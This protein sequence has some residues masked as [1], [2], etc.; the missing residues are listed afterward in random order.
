MA[1]RTR[2]A[3][4]EVDVQ[5]TAAGE[6]RRYR[7]TIRG[8]LQTAKAF[9]A[10]V[11][12][13]LLAGCKPDPYQ[14]HTPGRSGI[15]LGDALEQ[16]WERY[17]ANGGQART[18]RSNMAVCVEFFGKD[19]DLASIS[20]ADLD[21]FIMWMQRRDYAPSTIRSKYAVLSKAFRHFHRRGNLKTLPS[22]ELPQIGDNLR[23]R[24]VS[25]EEFGRLLG[26]LPPGPQQRA[27]VALFQL[28]LDT[29]ARRS[30]L[31]ASKGVDVRDGRITLRETKTGKSRVVPLTARAQQA[32]A[33][34]AALDPEAPCG[35]ATS[36]VVRHAWDYARNQMGLMGD[37]GFI[38]Y[39]LRHTCASRLYERTRDLMLVRDWLG[40]SDIKMTTR[41]AKLAPL[42]LDR[43][44]DL[45][46]G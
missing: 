13:D 14:G 29:G 32:W 5:V 38:P 6:K 10:R 46:E 44:R 37:E 21:D 45:L 16:V 17:W 42:S 40:H 41:Y 26:C 7:E 1:I 19:K 3:G 43:A 2:G 24:L 34:L 23:D 28:L 9:E 33:Y 18:V 11:R 4:L 35:W 36:G 25:E 39:A 15:P 22:V 31:W 30:E 20:N 12:A 8:D 27:L